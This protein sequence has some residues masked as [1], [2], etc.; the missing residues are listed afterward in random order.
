MSAY[1]HVCMSV[2][3]SMHVHVCRDFPVRVGTGVCFRAQVCG[4]LYTAHC[5]CVWHV[6]VVCPNCA[7]DNPLSCW[8]LAVQAGAE[9]NL[10][11]VILARTALNQLWYAVQVSVGS[12]HTGEQ[13]LHPWLALETAL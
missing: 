3:I 12:P 5:M 1:V 13:S 9:Q 7:A 10:S 4:V 11:W 8:L 6:W 2:C